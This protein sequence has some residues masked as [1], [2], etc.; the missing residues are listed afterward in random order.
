[1]IFYKYFMFV[2]NII[3]SL[4][5]MNLILCY[6]NHFVQQIR[7]WIDYIYIYIYIYIYASF[8]MCIG[9]NKINNNH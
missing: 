3:L 6:I 5:H 2:Q 8:D 9:P 7:P 4:C 1:M